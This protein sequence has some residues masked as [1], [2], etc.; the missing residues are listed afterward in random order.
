MVSSVVGTVK[1]PEDEIDAIWMWNVLI[2]DFQAW[3]VLEKCLDP[4]GKAWQRPGKG[5]SGCGSFDIK[6]GNCRLFLDTDFY[7]VLTDHQ[8]M[9]TFDVI[10]SEVSAE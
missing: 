5:F 9:L 8:C 2:L 7:D 4:P 10:Y 6:C 3:V 1:I